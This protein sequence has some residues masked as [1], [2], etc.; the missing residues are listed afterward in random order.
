M[1]DNLLDLEYFM[2]EIILE[3]FTSFL[4]LNFPVK[5]S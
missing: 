2:T 1:E 3:E 4:I 5:S